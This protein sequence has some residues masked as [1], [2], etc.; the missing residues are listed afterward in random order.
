MDIVAA[1]SNL[2]SAAGWLTISQLLWLIDNQSAAEARL[3][4]AATDMDM[5]R[6]VKVFYSKYTC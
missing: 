6:F 2:A 5:H 1:V 4:T 3:E